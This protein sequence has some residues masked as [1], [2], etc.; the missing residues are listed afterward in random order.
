[1]ITLVPNSSVLLPRGLSSYHDFTDA[2]RDQAIAL[3]LSRVSSASAYRP[4]ELPSS[5]KLNYPR[6]SRAIVP[7]TLAVSLLVQALRVS[8][9]GR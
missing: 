2:A 7:T 3:S 8:V 6:G 4:A 5:I 9:Q 1:M